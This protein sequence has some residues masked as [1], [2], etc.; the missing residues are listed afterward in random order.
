VINEIMLKKWLT[1]YILWLFQQKKNIHFVVNEIIK[2][3]N[4]TTQILCYKI[5]HLH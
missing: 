2:L 5:H 3:V 1:T 4:E